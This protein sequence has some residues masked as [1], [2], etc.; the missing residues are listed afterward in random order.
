MRLL[1]LRRKK[2]VY[3]LVFFF[4]NLIFLQNQSIKKNTVK[5]KPMVYGIRKFDEKNKICLTVKQE[6]Y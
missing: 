4:R 1:P 2:I 6:K 3:N 5:N